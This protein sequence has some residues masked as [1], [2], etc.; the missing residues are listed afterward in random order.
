MK[1]TLQNLRE[2]SGQAAE[3]LKSLAHPTRLMI[4]CHIGAEQRSVLELTDLLDT[5]QSNV[6]Q[7]LGKLRTMG[8]LANDKVGNQVFYRIADP[9]I[10]IFME[11]LQQTFCSPQ[12]AKNTYVNRNKGQHYV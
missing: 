6:S 3:V 8:V 4:L 5:T 9:S 11:Q 12:A 10:L 7:H 1:G 2:Q